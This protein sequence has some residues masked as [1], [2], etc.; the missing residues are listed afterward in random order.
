MKKIS[1]SIMAIFILVGCTAK[2][3]KANVESF[4]VA[5][6]GG[7]TAIGFLEMMEEYS[8]ENVEEEANVHNFEILGSP[9]EAVAK[10]LSGEVDIASVPANLASVLYNKTEGE[11][12]VVAIN[13]LGVL[14]VLES[15]DTVNSIEDLKGKTVYSTGKGA[16]PEY[17]FNHILNSAGILDDVTVEFKSEHAELAGLLANGSADI[18]VLPQPFV[19][20]AMAKNPDL[21]VALDLN[22]EWAKLDKG[23]QMVTGVLVVRNEVI[24]NNKE[25]LDE[26]L[27]EYQKSIQTANQDLE[28]TAKLAEKYGIMPEK[29]AIQAIPQ[30]NITYIDGDDMQKDLGNYLNILFEQNPKSVGGKLPD[31]NFYY[32]K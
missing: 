3:D 25:Q 16:T 32:K 6:L 24:E 9:D 17:A 8:E 15:G 18:A 7:P 21:R 20:S 1:L 23:G 19:T 31:E 22:A 11:I 26:F 13:T 2:Q 5:T 28:T 30:C 29:I 4:N 10:I 27:E 12:S 14:Y